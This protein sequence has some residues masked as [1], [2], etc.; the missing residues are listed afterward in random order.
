MKDVIDEATL[1]ALRHYGDDTCQQYYR[2][3]RDREFKSTR[4]NDCED[5]DYPPR[6]FCPSCHSSDVG[7]TD[8]PREGTI[9]AFT[10]NDRSFRFMPPDVVGLVELEG[11][12]KILTHIVGDL[13][14]LAIGQRV[15][16]EF[17]EIS[18]ELV[19][20]RFRRLS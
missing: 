2:H 12:G 17:H 5:I 16:L 1:D 20:H 9:Y 7:W 8:L 15:A 6:N 11:V 13:G 14:D 18:D 3:L 19:V 10:H 4:C